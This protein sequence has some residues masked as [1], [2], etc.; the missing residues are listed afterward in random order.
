MTRPSPSM[1]PSLIR[2]LLPGLLVLPV[3]LVAAACSGSS[4]NSSAPTSTSAAPGAPGRGS[5]TTTSAPTGTL[6]KIE[7]TT[8]KVAEL[9]Q[10]TA[11]AARPSS[12]DLYVAQRDGLI[13]LVKVTKPTTTGGSFRYQVQTTP[14]LDLS[15]VV[16]AGGE[17]G[18]LGVAFSSDGRKLYVDYT[19]KPDGRTVVAE[20]TLGDR[21]VADVKT[22]REL[23]VVKQ[24]A[25]NHN[26]G[27]LTIGPDGYLYVG[28]GDG[29]GSGDPSGN[30]QNR[31]Q[32]LGK[33]LRIDPEGATG[34]RPYGIP[35]GN[36]WA[37]G[38]DGAP[39]AWL[40]GVRN[41]W[42]FSFDKATGDLW[43][44]DVGQNAWEEINR[45]AATGGF[46][47]GRGANLGWDRMEGSH[48]FEGDNPDGGVLPIDEYSHD[49][50]CSVIGGYVY[51]G[52]AI[53][54]LRGTY[55]YTDYCQ[56]EIRAIQLHDGA[57]I[58]RRT[59]SL[60]LK[61]VFS[62]GQDNDGE[63]YVLQESGS[64]VKLTAP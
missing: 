31:K 42:R 7:L 18:L 12:P 39:E 50:G 48:R 36:P 59:W 34:S 57:I 10:P 28:L 11:M 63:L 14:V 16:A 35:A 40:F 51:R 37:D 38:E 22:R 25:P 9:E 29:G 30:A 32:L 27:D 41:P 52:S 4:T 1:R 2:V 5:T 56:S 6:D 53:E 8:V 17:Q 46:D 21:T 64:V 54:A 44:A 62:F 60:G 19:A 45:L 47:A 58:D 13:R 26:G 49:D 33:I 20:Y 55:L 24:P 3:L 61:N 43:V 23:L 15:K